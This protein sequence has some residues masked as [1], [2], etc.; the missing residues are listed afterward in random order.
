MPIRFLSLLLLVLCAWPLRAQDAAPPVDSLG[1]WR[2]L[3]SYRRGTYVTQSDEEIIY[4]TGRAIFYL[5]KDDL[6]I[7]R[8][9]RED[10]LAEARVRMLRYHGP[11]GTLIIVYESG[12]IDLL[13]DNQFSTLRQIENFNFNGDKT[14]N[15]LAFGPGNV[16]YIAAG[17]G[18]SALDLEEE[19]FLFTTFTG[20]AVED[21]VPFEG[22]LYAATPEGLYRAPLTGVNLNDFGNWDL[23]GPANGLPGDYSSTA[24]RVFEDQLYFGVGVDVYRLQADT[25][26]LFFDTD[27]ARA[28]QLEYLNPGP[29]N[30]L[31]GYRCTDEA[32]NSRQLMILDGAGGRERVFQQCI[33]RTNYALQDERGRIWFGEDEDVRRIRYLNAPGGTCNEIE[34][35]GPRSDDNFRLLHDG[36]ALWVAPAVLDEVFRPSF[37]FGGAYRFAD[38]RW[39]IY[40]R[41]NAPVFLGRDGARAGDDDVATIVDVHYDDVNDR[42]WFSS[43]YEGTIRWNAETESGELFDETNSTLSQAIGEAEGRIRVAGAVTDR[44]GFTYLA[45]A[46]AESGNIISVVSPD[47]QWAGLGQSCGL[48]N[49]LDVAIDDNGSIWVV[50]AT[51][52]GGGVTVLDPG[53]DP[54]DPGDD[55]CRTLTQTNTNLP[56]NSVRSIAV[57]LDGTVWVGTTQGIVLFACGGDPFNAEFC[58]GRR[59]V[60]IAGDFGAFLLENEEIRSIAVDGANRKW[61]G[62]SG[63]AFLLS[64]DGR[65]QLLF[66]D[67]GNSPLL[68]DLVRDIAIEG[69]TGTVYFGTELGIISYRGEATA[70]GRTFREELVVFPN[71]VQ[72]DYAGPI[73]IEGLAR[74]ARV[75]ITDLSGKLVADG[76][77]AGGRFIWDGADYN[78]RRV[79]TGVYLIFGSSN[80]RGI[81]LT[82]EAAV[83]KIVFIR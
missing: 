21:V 31:A 16:V 76:Q 72:P 50:H 53:D 59:P 39:D 65:E 67:A 70:A 74:D 11:T 20:V 66:F 9:A 7:R 23:L 48:N 38:G 49:A 45:N 2:T 18:V 75:K 69:E 17:Y 35:G 51:S 28:W 79:T 19:L 12:V 56:T 82:P 22:R 52:V 34:Y 8:L 46:Q 26:A 25:A 80:A 62:T 41:D 43:F 42:H 83:G 55:R 30:L 81:A 1:E 54:L 14:I 32:C 77:A 29:Q 37:N 63:G 68:D 27:D 78:G 64:P 57:D 3:H 24:A 4:T 44:N 47:G 61:I 33:F 15:E 58:G 40:N 10:G 71:P 13:R 5:D 6:S 73:A 36:E 60:A